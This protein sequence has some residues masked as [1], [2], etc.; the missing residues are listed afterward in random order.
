MAEEPKRLRIPPDSRVPVLFIS[1]FVLAYGV[2]V[3]I[4]GRIG[5]GPSPIEGPLAILLGAVFVAFSS[6]VFV[7][8]WIERGKA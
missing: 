1:P 3:I 7:I 6:I 8:A 4:T 5:R 2:W